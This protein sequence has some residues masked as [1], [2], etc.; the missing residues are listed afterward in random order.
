MN[1]YKLA[2]SSILFFY[3]TVSFQNNDEKVELTNRYAK[4]LTFLN[5]FATYI[6]ETG[7]VSISA[8]LDF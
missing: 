4:L 1:S 7:T 6:R 8:Q 2:Q 3:S 5:Y